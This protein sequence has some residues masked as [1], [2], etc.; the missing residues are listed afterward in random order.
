M[1][2]WTKN[3]VVGVVCCQVKKIAPDFYDNLPYHT[4]WVK[5]IWDY[6]FCADIGPYAR[7]KRRPSPDA[8][9]KLDEAKDEKQE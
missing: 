7:V 1:V 8:A 2:C 5:V 4:S 9:A 6:I 3:T